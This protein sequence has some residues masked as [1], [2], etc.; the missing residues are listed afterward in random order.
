MHTAAQSA[1]RCCRQSESTPNSPHFKQS[2]QT[3]Q[4]NSHRRQ[5]RSPTACRFRWR[6]SGEAMSFRRHAKKTKM[7]R[8]SRSQRRRTSLRPR[9]A[10]FMILMTVCVPGNESLLRCA[11]LLGI[12]MPFFGLSIPVIFVISLNIRKTGSVLFRTAIPA[13]NMNK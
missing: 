6:M 10:L 13:P 9:N 1:V 11:Q 3:V 2:F 4:G 7:S 12:A 5:V 8:T